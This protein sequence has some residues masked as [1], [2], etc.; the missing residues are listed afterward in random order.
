MFIQITA[1]RSENQFQ[2]SGLNVESFS[3]NPAGTQWLLSEVD[4]AIWS[5]QLATNPVRDG[6][7]RRSYTSNLAALNLNEY[8]L[9]TPCSR[10]LPE[11]LTVP[12]LVDTFPR[13]HGKQGS[14]PWSQQRPRCPCPVPDA[15]PS[16]PTSYEIYLILFAH[17]CRYLPRGLFPPMNFTKRGMPHPPL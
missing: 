15:S 8:H 11:K 2:L 3:V 6:M 9:T 5:T 12:Q 14:L 7:K 16:P 17:L 4:T 1:L 10:V 13:P